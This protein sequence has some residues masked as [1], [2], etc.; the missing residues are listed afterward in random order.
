MS[1][2][3]FRLQSVVEEYVLGMDWCIIALINAGSTVKPL[4]WAAPKK[5]QT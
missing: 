5:P 2:I 3:S 4:I 1:D